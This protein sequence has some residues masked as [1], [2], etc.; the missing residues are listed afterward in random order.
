LFVE[1]DFARLAEQLERLQPTAPKVE[2]PLEEHQQF[3]ARLLKLYNDTFKLTPTSLALSPDDQTAIDEYF[4]M[5]RLMVQ[6]QQEASRV[7]PQ[8][9]NGILAKMLLPAVV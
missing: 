6:C 7:S 2:A 1:V 8:T 3:A 4:Y 5:N 9:W